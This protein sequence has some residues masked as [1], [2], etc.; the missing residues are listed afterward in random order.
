MKRKLYLLVA[1]SISSLC[2]W[3]QSVTIDKITYSLYDRDGVT[4]AQVSGSDEDITEVNIRTTVVIDGVEYK[5][6]N[7]GRGAFDNQRKI[8]SIDVPEG[9]LRIEEHSMTTPY[10]KNVTIPASVTFIERYWDAFGQ[11]IETISVAEGNPVYDSRDNCNGIMLTQENEAY[12]IFKNTIIPS[13]IHTLGNFSVKYN[14]DSFVIPE[15]ITKLSGP[16]FCN[17]EINYVFFPKTV[18][19]CSELSLWCCNIKRLEVDKD[20]PYYYSEDNCLI[21]KATEKLIAIGNN[22]SGV[23]PINV[24]D[25]A[26]HDII[27]SYGKPITMLSEYPFKL[28]PG[29]GNFDNCDLIVPTGSIPRYLYQ[30]WCNINFKSISDGISKYM[31]RAEGTN[32]WGAGFN[33]EKSVVSKVGEEIELSITIHTWDY[34]PIGFQFDLYLPDGISLVH[35]EYG[36]P[37][38]RLSTEHTTSA[39]H[40]LDYAQRSDGS[41]RIICTS[42]QWDSFSGTD[43]EVCTI[44][45]KVDENLDYGSY[46]IGLRN[47]TVTCDDGQHKTDDYIGYINVMPEPE[48]V[49]THDIND[50]NEVNTQDVMQILKYIRTGA[51]GGKQVLEDVNDDGKVDTQDVLL[52]YKYM[53][54]H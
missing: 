35:D 45:V 7:I 23:I 36:E 12:N 10:L 31:L 18:I 51:Q 14:F 52:I 42:K 50:D 46:P 5:V 43:G 21:E 26:P 9:I 28:V 4:E 2:A 39:K 1:F 40:S 53:K 32:A 8:T 20:N 22:F 48:V 13:S 11:G 17:R 37:F 49:K 41:W 24:K 47:R 16:V 29:V 34:P 54:E 44:R 33:S 30:G 3:S 6:T 19:D 25:F 27:W 15:H 38:I